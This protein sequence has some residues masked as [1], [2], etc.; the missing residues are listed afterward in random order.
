MALL[1]YLLS[2]EYKNVM[3]YYLFVCFC[4]RAIMPLHT[5]SVC[6][7]GWASV[8]ERNLKTEE[9]ELFP[10]FSKTLLWNAA[11]CYKK[12]KNLSTK[13][14]EIQS[15]PVLPSY[16]IYSHIVC[17][18][19][20]WKKEHFTPRGPDKWFPRSG[21]IHK[22]NNRSP[23]PVMTSLLLLP[24]TLT[25]FSPLEGL[26]RL[27]GQTR[28]GVAQNTT[29]RKPV[30]SITHW[31]AQAEIPCIDFIGVHLPSLFSQPHAVFPC[32]IVFDQNRMSRLINVF[33]LL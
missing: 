5:H 19:Q 11:G 30:V 21:V 17:F 18:K 29:L 28:P 20:T 14:T 2:N 9:F 4:W 27:S 24:V 12:K 23:N 13:M 32:V 7:L 16:A 10:T 31:T 15:N 8:A 33:L 26:W 3:L 22:G 25:L 1:W 6:L